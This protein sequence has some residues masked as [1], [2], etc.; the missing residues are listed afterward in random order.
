MLPTRDPPQNKEHI[1]TESEGVQKDI[2]EGS[3]ITAYGDC[4][5]EILK[6]PCSL[7]E[8]LW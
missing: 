8:N 2:L 4:S 6:D 7:E 3:E 1:R 5:H